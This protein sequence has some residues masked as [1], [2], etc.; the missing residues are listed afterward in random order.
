MLIQRINRTD[1]EK[2]FQVVKNS[3]STAITVG[4]VVCYDYVTDADGVGVTTPTAQ[5]L[6]L[7]AGIV[8]STSIAASD[9]GLIQ[10]YGHNAN[11][12]VQGGTDVATGDQLAAKNAVFSLIKAAA[13]L[14]DAEKAFFVAG[15]D[16]S[17]STAAAKK[18]FVRAL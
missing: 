9:F 18:V 13:T 16:F 17:T 7:V 14:N 15:E 8:E 6:P 5:L 2:V 10:I 11:A 3:I 1:A 4:Q 12:L